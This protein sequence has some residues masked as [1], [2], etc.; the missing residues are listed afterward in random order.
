MKRTLILITLALLGILG[1][2]G[3][4]LIKGKSGLLTDP[5][6]SIPGSA[7]IIIETV[8]IRSFVNSATAERG[9]LSELRN[10]SE[11]GTFSNKLKF[12]AGKINKPAFNE[13]LSDGRALISWYPSSGGKMKSLLSVP[14]SSGITY[15]KLEQSLVSAGFTGI[16]ESRFNGSRILW[17]EGMQ[18]KDTAFITLYSG[19]LLMSD[20]QKLVSEATKSVSDG[21]DIRKVD[22]FSKVQMASG[23]GEDKI[24]VVFQ[25]LSGIMKSLLNSNNFKS[26]LPRSPAIAGEGDIYLSDAGLV[27]SG[28]TESRDS[29]G[30]LNRVRSAAPAEMQT[31]RVL[32]AATS[33]FETIIYDNRPQGR[34]K[35]VPGFPQRIADSLGSVVGDEI[36]RA[37]INF[38]E[39][40]E[41]LKSV[42]IYKLTSTVRAEQILLGMLPDSSG[43]VRFK[44]DEQVN[45]PVYNLHETGLV[46][47]FIPEFGSSTCDSLV[48][49]YDN[50]MI[51]GGSHATLNRILYDNILNNTLAYN[52]SYRDF[53]NSLPSRAGYF[54]YCVP[55]DI[56]KKASGFLSD[57]IIS[58]MSANR[59]I[60][61][62]I[63]SAG[64][65]LASSNEMIYSSLSVRY[66]NDVVNKS[67][68][69][70]E[71]LLD[72]TAG[73]KPCFFTNHLTGAKEIFVQDL[74]NNIYLI[75]AAGRVLWKVPLQERIEGTVYMIDYYRNGKYQLLFN[76]RNYLHLIDRNGNYVE[77]YPV[78]LRSPATN[79]LA[80]FDYDNNLN[81][82][83]L[84]AGE[85]RQIYSYDRSGSIVK[86]WKLFRTPGQVRTQI[87]YFQISGKD[88]IAVSDETS[89]FFLD[90]SGNKRV[91]LK[92]QVSRA[93]GSSLKVVP[94]SDPYFVC[95]SSDG[96]I[97]HIY[98]DGS[99][100][101]YNIGNFS[102][103]HLFDIFDVDGDGFDEYIFIDKGKIYLY[104]HN[105]SE[106]FSKDLKS[107]NLEGPITFSFSAENRKIGVLDAANDLIYLLDNEGTNMKGFPLKGASLFSIGKLAGRSNWNLIVAGPGRFLY[108]YKIET[109]EL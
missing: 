82:R 46:K 76:S 80:L 37:Y 10:F 22:G 32:P 24:F 52:I 57:T 77:R 85:D 23:K 56:L 69:E 12:I 39:R 99:V 63:T 16:N 36:T 25:N 35:G 5:Y 98:P 3:Y 90:R 13:I 34:F 79:S 17:F 78:K 62:K 109:G 28:Y 47:S 48:A 105:R 18:P 51:T 19:L 66:R 9:L 72:T 29:S 86:G 65:R 44:P 92:E 15:R 42:V 6:S 2:T 67:M 64:F 74:K 8:D 45:I 14:V 27:L 40:D 7:C 108:N 61:D 75:N 97:Q 30:L 31:Y 106:L 104:D 70:W 100:K 21:S 20:S 96:T 107:D 11:L 4:F 50:Y 94:G 84:I 71:T 83:I 93:K 53:E 43:I 101:K 88:Y 58:A 95:T 81:Y 91:S 41:A 59:N 87:S 54:F 73:T 38:N 60:L 49:F 33:M 103:G 55:S 102:P 1:G 26:G 89:L 68:T